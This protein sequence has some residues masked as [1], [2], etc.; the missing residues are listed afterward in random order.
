M[1]RVLLLNATFEPLRLLTARRAVLLLL[2]ER[3]EPVDQADEVMTVHSPT[4]SITVPSVVRL[5]RYVRIP[6]EAMSPP[7][8]RRGVLLRDQHRCAYCGS[9]A[10]TIDHVV[11]KSRGG[12]HEWTNIVAACRKHNHDKGN[13]LLEELGWKLR[14]TPRAPQGLLWRICDEAEIRPGWNLFL[15][16]S[17]A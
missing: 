17:A 12:H 2:E 16:L 10:D 3:A 9:H 13:S 7:V 11:P 4:R 5:T 15:G 1:D 6:R 14:V 8:S